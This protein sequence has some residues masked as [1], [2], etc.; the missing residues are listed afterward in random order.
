MTIGG[1]VTVFII[2]AA[3]LIVCWGFW[4]AVNTLAPPP[5][6]AP[7]QVL[8]VVVACIAVALVLVNMV[9]GLQM[10]VSFTDHALPRFG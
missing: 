5:I 3:I 7:L 1:I 4:Y 2:I 8:I 10:R 6:K 9:G